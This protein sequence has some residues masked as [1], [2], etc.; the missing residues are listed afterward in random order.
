MKKQIL[1]AKL[2]PRLFSTLM[3][4]SLFLII[5]TPFARMLNKYVFIKKFGD[6][7]RAKNVDLDNT[8]AIQKA[9]QS[10]EFMQHSNLSTFLEIAAPMFV[11]Q[12]LAIILYFVVLWHMFGVTPVKYF[13]RMK[14]VDATTLEK[15]TIYQSFK[16]LCGYALFP[17]GIWWMFFTE[18][19][20]MLHDK[21]AGTIVIKY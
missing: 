14:V 9:L 11:M 20:Q 13:M 5:L 15:P 8:E 6:I 21:M 1:Y 18:K 4:W 3:D 10:P 7:L 19:K 17:I 16:R 12:S 2:M